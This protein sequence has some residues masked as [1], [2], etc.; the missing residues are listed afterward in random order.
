MKRVLGKGIAMM[1]IMSLAIVGCNKTDSNPI[2]KNGATL[3]MLKSKHEA[4]IQKFTK[5]ADGAFDITGKGGVKISFPAESLMDKDGQPVSG[6]VNITLIEIFT[7]KDVLMSG[8]D[9]E[10]YGALLET[11]GQIFVEAD[12]NG[13][14]LKLNPSKNVEVVFPKDPNQTADN[15]ILFVARPTNE[16]APNNEFTWSVSR[17][18]KLSADNNNYSFRL[19]E[20]NWINIDRFINDG[21]P[22]TDISVTL[23]GSQA[24]GNVYVEVWIIFKNIKS[25]FKVPGLTTT[26]GNYINLLPLGEDIKL[27]VVGYNQHGQMYIDSRDLTTED[28]KTYTMTPK[29][30][31]QAEMDDF[32]SS[33]E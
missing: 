13:E 31:T 5:N 30:V 27:A 7:K 9:T 14:K 11:G 25:A 2:L 12:K 18:S 3:E 16:E 24:T 29:P 8:L 10:S 20:L 23:D 33:L 26:V 22:K 17:Q 21:K 15:M 1:A 4:P 28:D 32:M 6:T 19:P